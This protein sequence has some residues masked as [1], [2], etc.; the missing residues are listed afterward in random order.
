MAYAQDFDFNQNRLKINRELALT[1]LA[2]LDHNSGSFVFT[3][4]LVGGAA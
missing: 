4:T 1:Q 3:L 2:V